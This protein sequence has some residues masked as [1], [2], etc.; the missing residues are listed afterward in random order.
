MTELPDDFDPAWYAQRYPDV[1]LSGL[2]PQD[3]YRRF[4]RHFGRSANGKGER[5]SIAERVPPEAQRSDPSSLPVANAAV[6]PVASAPVPIIDRP[7]NFDPT[8]G[9]ALPLEAPAAH[10]TPLQVSTQN[11][12]GDPAL[13]AYY[14]LV[15]LDETG[16][17]K[18]ALAPF[19]VSPFQSGPTRIEN[20][21]FV[22][23]SRLRLMLAGHAPDQVGAEQLVLR[24]YQAKPSKP[25]ELL[26]LEP[27]LQLAPAGPVFHD[28]EL[29][30]SLMPVLLELSRADGTVLARALMPFPSLLPGGLHNAEL[31]ALQTQANPMDDFWSASDVLLREAVGGSDAAPRSVVGISQEAELDH[32]LADEVNEWLTTLFALEP[33]EKIGRG[34][35]SGG[36]DLILPANAVPTIGILV[37]RQIDLGGSPFLAGPY[38]L[39]EAESLR[40]RWSIV[41]PVGEERWKGVPVVR[42]RPATAASGSAGRPAP[43]HLA[44]VL[45]PPVA[46]GCGSG[47]APENSLDRPISALIEVADVAQARTTVQALRDSA[48][49]AGVEFLFRLRDDSPDLRAALDGICGVA[50][51][52]AVSWDADLIEIAQS[53]RHDFILTIGDRVRLDHPDVVATLMAILDEHPDA[54]SASCALLGETIVKR[55]TVVTPASG[56]LFP[57]GVSFAASPRL[58]FWEPDV[59]EALPQQTF[60]V[61]A[62]TMHLTLLRKEALA[63][64]PGVG[65]A[66]DIRLGLD[67]IE[68]GYRN[69]CTTKA[70]ATLTG[71]YVRRDSIDPVGG[72][73]AEIG[74]WQELLPR[75]ALV[76]QLY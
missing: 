15:R 1:G 51:W 12:D 22:G 19:A 45:Q 32:P 34:H 25:G 7:A 9:L 67:L 46:I 69:W 66:D 52:S 17:Q 35:K 18:E 20:A 6:R 3:H 31:K 4:G 53:A 8:E 13:V 50:A 24:A 58:S 44:I 61:A 60:P 55:Q 21:W 40:P 48:G 41:P 29:L 36:F 49:N 73:Y 63:K 56:G 38:L 68:A 72:A 10:G 59:L 74:R 64:L 2:S 14:R 47:S 23:R 30:Q 5:R 43:I 62:N 37:S 11:A 71:G 75:V 57:A 33:S 42:S 70:T 28:F 26:P 27:A 65:R 76:R 54:G 16:L 39:A